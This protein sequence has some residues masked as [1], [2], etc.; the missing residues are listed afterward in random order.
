MLRGDSGADT[1]NGGAGT[2]TA[3]LCRVVRRGVTVLLY[4]DFDVFGR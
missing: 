4:T 3:S 2:D 1:L